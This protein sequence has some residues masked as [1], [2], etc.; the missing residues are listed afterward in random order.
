MCTLSFIQMILL[1]SLTSNHTGP[2]PLRETQQDVDTWQSIFR[3]RHHVLRQIRRG[4]ATMRAFSC[5]LWSSCLFMMHLPGTLFHT[6]NM[7]LYLVGGFNPSEKYSSKWESSHFRGLKIKNVWNRHLGYVFSS[8][9][10]RS[11]LAEGNPFSS[12]SSQVA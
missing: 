11:T 5:F 10:T 9:S 6:R 3:Q 4:R 7:V 8:S 2:K 12:V 1:G